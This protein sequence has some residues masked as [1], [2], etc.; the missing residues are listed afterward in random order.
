MAF[1]VV[2]PRRESTAVLRIRRVLITIACV[3]MLFFTWSMY[4][5]IWQVLHIDLRAS[6]TVIAPGTTVSYDVITS[7]ETQNRILLQVVQGAHAETLLE[8]RAR[9]NSVSAYDPRVFQ[10][11]P[12]ITITGE[13]LARFEPGPATLRLT[14]FGGQKLLRTPAPRVREMKVQISR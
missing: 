10:Y 8:Q 2:M 1:S 6:S 5:R 3:H 4:R 9:V 7:G 11:T 14:G 13:M 12:T